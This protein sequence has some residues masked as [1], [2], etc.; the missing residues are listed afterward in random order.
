MRSR[1]ILS[2]IVLLALAGCGSH[3]SNDGGL[4]PGLVGTVPAPPPPGQPEVPCLPSAPTTL[5]VYAR[6]DTKEAIDVKAT[7]P[8]ETVDLGQ[9]DPGQSI[10]CDLGELPQ[11]VT[12][13]A[14]SQTPDA[15]GVVETFPDAT[16][17][18]GTDYSD[19]SPS[20]SMDWEPDP[21]ATDSS[22]TDNSTDTPSTDTPPTDT[23]PTDNSSTSPD[24][25]A[26]DTVAPAATTRMPVVRHV[27]P[28][29]TA[30]RVAGVVTRRVTT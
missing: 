2:S 12:F 11:Y 21:S 26:A 14:T 19:S 4:E 27:A 25:S 10:S 24:P 8:D 3:L 13:S 22:T 29:P 18:A 6:N 9:V 20:V 23:P 16:S 28:S 15:S 30:V 5:V 17:W 1:A 7:T